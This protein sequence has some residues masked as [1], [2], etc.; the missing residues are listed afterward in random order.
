MGCDTLFNFI[1]DETSVYDEND[2]EKAS[3][4][5]ISFMNENGINQVKVDINEAGETET[6]DVYYLF[7]VAWIENGELKLF[8]CYV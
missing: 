6:A 2:F 3:N 8:N 5:I 7:S 1:Y 4:S